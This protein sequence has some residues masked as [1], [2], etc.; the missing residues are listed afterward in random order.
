MHGVLSNNGKHRLCYHE[1]QGASHPPESGA[2]HSSHL[3]ANAHVPMSSGCMQ[4]SKHL[5]TELR[6]A[7][8]AAGIDIHIV[9]PSE[10]LE[11]QDG[12]PFQAI[13]HK[14]R[15]DAGT[16]LQRCSEAGMQRAGHERLRSKFAHQSPFTHRTVRTACMAGGTAHAVVLRQALR[17]RSGSTRPRTAASP[18][19]TTSTPSGR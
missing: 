4:A 18:S 12:H 19:S 11:A 2:A 7:A 8:Q 9:N 15:G 5:S 3:A 1:R 14:V 13:V 16:R 17:R 6:Q 10:P